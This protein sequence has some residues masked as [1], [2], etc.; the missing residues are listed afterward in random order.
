M[1]PT[2]NR[3]HCRNLSQVSKTLKTNVHHTI[4]MVTPLSSENAI[5][6][7]V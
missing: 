4:R 5:L 7:V 6:I 2:M 3:I 1:C